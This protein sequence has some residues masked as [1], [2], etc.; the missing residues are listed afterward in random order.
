MM[1]MLGGAIVMMA[2]LGGAIVM[3]AMLGGA[4]VMIAV[5][6]GVAHKRMHSTLRCSCCGVFFSLVMVFRSFHR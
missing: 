3:M 1:A 2:M 6:G 4:I 5:L